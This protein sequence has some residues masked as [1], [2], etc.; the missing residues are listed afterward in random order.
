MKKFI[1]FITIFITLFLLCGVANAAGL[2]YA[3]SSEGEINLYMTPSDSGFVI[4]KIPA[5][6]ELEII[7]TERTWALVSFRSKVGWI[8]LSFTR[9]S[10]LDAAEASGSDMKSSVQVKAKNGQATLYNIPS[11]DTTLGSEE[12]Y[13]VP[14]NTV[15]E[16]KRQISSKWGLV[17]MSGDYAWIKM[18][19]VK[20]FDTHNESEIYGIYYVYTL[21][22]KGDGVNLF[23]DEYG[24]NLCAVIPDCVKLTVQETQNGYGRVSYDGTEGWVN[25]ENTTQSLLNA[26]SNAGEKV[27]EE[28][29]V[30][31]KEEG[32]TFS[33]YSVPSENPADGTVEIGTVKKGEYVYVLRVTQN[34]W[35]LINCDGQLG[36]LPPESLEEKK[37]SQYSHKYDN[38]RISESEKL[39][40]IATK[41]GKGLKVYCEPGSAKVISFIPETA[42]I[43]IMAEENGYKYVYSDFASGWVKEECSFE[44]R[45]EALS[46]YHNKKEKAYITK[47][48][49]LLMKLPLTEQYGENAI[50]MS[51]P[52]GKRVV[53]VRTVT[54]GKTKWLL[55]KVDGKYGWVNK[56]D[57]QQEEY[58]IALC[59]TI[60]G[61]LLAIGVALWLILRKLK[62]KIKKN[63]EKEV[64][65][66]EKSVHDENSGT[67]E[68]SPTLSRK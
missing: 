54:S 34:G 41:Q 35:S 64:E 39:S 25:L 42:K 43:K 63:K 23:V 12:K 28:F 3:S 22:D 44:T 21:S 8:N 67:Y 38:I 68:E 56:A 27:N 50:L 46:M 16:I 59:L 19:E 9:G 55:V 14:N 7:K 4:T 18:D 10:Y 5:C 48:A 37:Y 15:L 17:S 40:Y 36:W 20:S 61:G 29:V 32:N 13:Q 26:Q 11:E 2:K 49:T 65:E 53:A 57:V 51:V 60:L 66:I 45:K 58:L 52:K 6:S 62:K 31:E 24:E 30:K 1:G 47:K 33:V